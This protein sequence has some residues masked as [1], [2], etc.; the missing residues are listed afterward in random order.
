MQKLFEDESD[1]TLISLANIDVQNVAKT[2]NGKT[3]TSVI[4]CLV[5]LRD[6]LDTRM[7]ICMFPGK[8]IDTLDPR[9]VSALNTIRKGLFGHLNL[10][11]LIGVDKPFVKKEPFKGIAS[12]SNP[13]SSLR[14]T[15]ERASTAFVVGNALGWPGKHRYRYRYW[16]L[17]CIKRIAMTATRRAIKHHEVTRRIDRR[18]TR[19]GGGT[20]GRG[21]G[22]G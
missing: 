12:L 15:F 8:H 13:E 4:T 18:R 22:G 20:D 11:H 7:A 2:L 21:A 3:D 9:T 14:F 16:C 6:G 1:S 19:S 10:C 17:D 5:A